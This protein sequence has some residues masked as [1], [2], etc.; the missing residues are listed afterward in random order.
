VNKDYGCVEKV[1]IDRFPEN[2]FRGVIDMMEGELLNYFE[3]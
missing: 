2:I 3:D 1:P